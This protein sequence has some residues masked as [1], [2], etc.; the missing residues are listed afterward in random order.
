MSSLIK[1]R[2][3]RINGKKS[4]IVGYKSDSYFSRMKRS[5]KENDFLTYIVR[6]TL[7]ADSNVL[8]VGANIGVTSVLFAGTATAGQVHSFEPSPTAFPLLQAT[9]EA[10]DL[11]NVT[12]HQL[13]CGAQKGQLTFFDNPDSAS[14]SHLAVADRTLG[15]SNATVEVT[16]LDDFVQERGIDRLDLVKIDVEGLELDVLTGASDVLSRLKPGVFLEF[17]SFTLIA[18]GNQNPRFVLETLLERFAHVYRFEDGKPCEIRDEDSV[19]TFIH[20]NL[21]KRRSVD[22]LYCSHSELLP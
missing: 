18:Y 4:T 13:A 5:R 3:I 21:L 16:T 17:N 15:Q 14:A 11:A 20:D 2:T 7:R 9:I 10:N 8:D 19:L 6:R 22:D 12:A 1:S